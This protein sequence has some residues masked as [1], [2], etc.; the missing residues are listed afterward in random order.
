MYSCC[1]KTSRTTWICDG[2]RPIQPCIGAVSQ[3]LVGYLKPDPSGSTGTILSKNSTQQ[4]YGMATK[5]TKCLRV[6]RHSGPDPSRFQKMQP[7]FGHLT[8]LP[9]YKV[10]GIKLDN[11]S[12][13]NRV[14]KRARDGWIQYALYCTSCTPGRFMRTQNVQYSFLKNL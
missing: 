2:Y 10:R 9:V 6:P 8:P 4:T 13:R 5:N 1:A 3:P 12:W 11:T 14:T 7:R